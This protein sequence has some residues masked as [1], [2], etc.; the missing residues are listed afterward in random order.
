MDERTVHVFG[1][2]QLVY[3]AP[4]VALGILRFLMLALWWPKDESPTEAML[5]DF[6]CLLDLAAA[7]A[8]I[9]YIIY[10]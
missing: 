1:T 8:T 3:S 10:G 9:L 2:N 6:L 4:F 5:K 7:V